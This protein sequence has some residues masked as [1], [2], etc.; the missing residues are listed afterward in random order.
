[1]AGAAADGVPVFGGD[2]LLAASDFGSEL[3][4]VAYV[5]AAAGPGLGPGVADAAELDAAAVDRSLSGF[6]LISV[7]F[8]SIVA[9]GRFGPAPALGV[10]AADGFLG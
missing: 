2:A 10:S 8:K 1:M 9:N 6:T 5:E 7:A 3:D 4:A